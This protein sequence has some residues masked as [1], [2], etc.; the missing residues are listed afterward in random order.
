MAL[1]AIIDITSG[2]SILYGNNSN[3]TSQN[4]HCPFGCDC[5][6]PGAVII[7]GELLNGIP[8]LPINTSRLDYTSASQIILKDDL[9]VNKNCH[10]VRELTLFKNEIEKIESR[11]FYPFYQ[12]RYL[13]LRKNHIKEL[14]ATHFTNNQFLQSLDLS[15]NLFNFMPIKA[16]CTLN[17]LEQLYLGNNPWLDISWQDPCLAQ[18]I[19]L[20]SISLSRSNLKYLL[21]ND[22][23]LALKNSSIEYLNLESCKI[24][25]LPASM[26]ENLPRLKVLYLESN[27]IKAINQ[28]EL[29]SLVNLEAL[30]LTSNPIN[31]FDMRTLTLCKNFKEIGINYVGGMTKHNIEILAGQPY[32]ETLH[33]IEGYRRNITTDIFSAF[34]KSIYL[35]NFTLSTPVDKI[36]PKSF[37]WFPALEKLVLIETKLNSTQFNNVLGGLSASVTYIDLSNNHFM[38]KLPYTMFSK[39]KAPDNVRKL[40]LQSCSLSG[41]IPIEELAPLRNLETLD[42]AYNELT[43]IAITSLQLPKLSELCLIN[44]AIKDVKKGVFTAFPNLTLLD[45]TGNAIKHFATSLACKGT[46]KIKTII[47]KGCQLRTLSSMKQFSMLE[48]LDLRNNYIIEISTDMFKGLSHLQKLH[49]D[50]N[51]I[52]HLNR[53]IFY[54]LHELQYLSIE[55]NNIE[56]IHPTVLKPLKKLNHLKLA[57]NGLAELNVSVV[58]HLKS[59]TDIGLHMNPLQCTCDTLPLIKWLHKNNIYIVGYTLDKTVMCKY[60]K[61]DINLIDFNLTEYDC[62][63]I[64]TVITISLVW[65]GYCLFVL[66]LSLA[67]RFRWYLMYEYVLLRTKVY[68]YRAARRQ[69]SYVFDAFVL[70]SP[71]DFEWVLDKLLNCVE[72]ENNMKLCL[73]ERNWLGGRNTVSSIAGCIDVSKH[74]VLVVSNAW[75][76]STKCS[77][78]M[79]MARLV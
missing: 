71:K 41:E 4:P 6:T 20:K 69:P 9:C 18:L 7:I 40:S 53:D 48:N 3:L 67:Y 39:M 59:L 31:V 66:L 64:S 72:K 70:C 55:K 45:V 46:H 13:Q 34:N 43:G 76:K 24:A 25:G 78:D 28:P 38:R 77:D 42:F 2:Y 16:L 49:V 61:R 57:N 30:H 58:Q 5:R 63:S 23:F 56:Y 79:S 68:R 65:I 37:E 17:K 15:G 14:S 75:A 1:Q 8:V 21:H 26:F 12:L 36:E 52:A 44:N 54:D 51:G 19:N 35:K 33:I 27:R 73:E 29:T 60:K 11:T 22:T 32:I 74:V 10:S 47:L 62:S 50:Y